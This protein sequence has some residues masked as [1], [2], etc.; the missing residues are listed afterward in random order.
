MR[1]DPPAG[2][3][4]AQPYAAQQRAVERALPDPRWV[5]MTEPGPPDESTRFS[6][7][8]SDGAGRD[9]FVDPGPPRSSATSTPTPP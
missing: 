2:T 4:V 3:D 9:S 1:V 8:L 7:T 6:V 5:S